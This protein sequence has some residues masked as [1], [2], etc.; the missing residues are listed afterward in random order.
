MQ[1]VMQAFSAF[2][3]AYSGGRSTAPGLRQE[4]GRRSAEAV[5]LRRLR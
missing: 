3:V 2:Q 5:I 4:K 1:K